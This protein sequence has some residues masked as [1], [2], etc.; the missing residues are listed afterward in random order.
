MGHA[1]EAKLLTVRGFS[2]IG[3]GGELLLYVNTEV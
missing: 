1:F 3:K 2:L